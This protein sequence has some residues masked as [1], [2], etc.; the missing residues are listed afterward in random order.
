MK[1]IISI[2]AILMIAICH[3]YAEEAKIPDI[4][5]AFPGEKILIKS[6][7]AGAE[8]CAYATDIDFAEL[9]KKLKAFLG[10]GWSEM[11]IGQDK[12]EMNKA[13]EAQGIKV[14]GSTMY[15]SDEFP[16]K[17]LMF[18]QLEM[19]AGVTGDKKTMAQIVVSG[20]PENVDQ[21]E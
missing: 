2:T 3:S 15:K 4:S 5:K 17:M 11:K 18:T 9:S 14:L 13:F 12:E 7:I 20:I 16:D 10:K 8:T 1:K 21:L 19:P 6:S